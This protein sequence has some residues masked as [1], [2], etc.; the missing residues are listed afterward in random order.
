MTEQEKKE[1]DFLKG[2]LSLGRRIQ[3]RFK[4][5]PLFA[6]TGVG[7]LKSEGVSTIAKVKTSVARTHAKRR[8]LRLTHA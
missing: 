4:P 7:Y 2:A 5:E 8:A 1:Q 6:K 3:H